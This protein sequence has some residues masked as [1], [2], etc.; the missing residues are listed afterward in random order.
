MVK[1]RKPFEGEIIKCWEK[2][3]I[4][5]KSRTPLTKQDSQVTQGF[6]FLSEG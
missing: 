3:N 1:R 4:N 5:A 2:V 6:T